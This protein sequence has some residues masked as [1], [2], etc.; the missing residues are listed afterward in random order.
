M[1]QPRFFFYILYAWKNVCSRC[2]HWAKQMNGGGSKKEHKQDEGQEIWRV[3]QP[4][5]NIYLA[6][7]SQAEAKWRLRKCIW[8][9][10]KAAHDGGVTWTPKYLQVCCEKDRTV[11]SRSLAI[12][13]P[14]HFS[15]LDIIYFSSFILTFTV[16]QRFRSHFFTLASHCLPF[17]DLMTVCCSSILWSTYPARVAELEDQVLNEVGWI[18]TSEGEK[19]NRRDRSETDFES[20]VAAPTN[21]FQLAY[22][23][24]SANNFWGQSDASVRSS[25]GAPLFLITHLNYWAVR[26]TVFAK[27]V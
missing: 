6:C 15:I 5:A 21:P 23:S 7:Q 17:F 19:H 1:H 24:A 9:S 16:F 2:Q 3:R 8:V 26:E 20:Q 14:V 13:L 18:S 4:A 22:L 27:A 11:W 12:T 10:I 25:Q